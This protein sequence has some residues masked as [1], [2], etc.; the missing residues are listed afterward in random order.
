[1]VPTEDA[2]ITFRIP[3]RPEAGLLV[4]FMQLKY[5]LIFARYNFFQFLTFKA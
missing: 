5:E 1:M 3:V 2:A 4:L